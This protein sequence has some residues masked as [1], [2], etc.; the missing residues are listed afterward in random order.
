MRAR[1]M[2]KVTIE[3]DEELAKLILAAEKKLE[4][5]AKAAKEFAPLDIEGTQGVLRE[6]TNSVGKDLQRR[7][8]QSL[9]TD[10]AAV[11]ISG[12][13]CV[14]VGRYETTFRTLEG[15]VKVTRSLYRE[16]GVRNGPTMDAGSARLGAV[17]D[18]WT[19]EAAKAMAFLHTNRHHRERLRRSRS[20]FIACRT[21][22]AASRE[23]V[24]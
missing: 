12:K 16:R 4:E 22:E 6:T 3:V 5:Q 10:E 13:R 2:A 7:W 21:R 9:D 19:P 15:P 1:A 17:A 8:L 23:S 20:S 11:V 24:T 14:K 18:G